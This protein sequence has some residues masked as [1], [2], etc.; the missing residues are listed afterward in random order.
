MPDAFLCNLHFREDVTKLEAA[1]RLGSCLPEIQRHGLEPLAFT[2]PAWRKSDLRVF[3]GTS[4]IH[5]QFAKYAINQMWGVGFSFI[6]AAAAEAT[7]ISMTAPAGPA[8][9]PVDPWDW[10]VHLAESICISTEAEF[11]LVSGF[12]FGRGQSSGVGGPPLGPEVAPGNPP[13]VVCPWMYWG[14]SRLNDDGVAKG[15]AQ[16]SETAF[17]SSSASQKGWVLQAREEYSEIAPHNF[18][19]AYASVF[20]LPV[21]KWIAVA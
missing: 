5:P 6:Y 14:T 13:R 17:R 21:P 7:I 8:E 3:G 15:L 19:L 1:S 11:S 9:L 20:E 4:L 18:L 10:L 2:E 12:R 16:L